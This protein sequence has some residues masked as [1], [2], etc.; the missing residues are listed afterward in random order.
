MGGL[1][2]NKSPG[3]DGLPGEFFRKFKKRLGP[4]LIRLFAD[5]QRERRVGHDFATGIVALIHKRGDKAD[6]RNYRPITLLNCDYKILMKVM[7]NR[8]KLVIEQVISGGQAYSVPGRDIAD[9]I[10]SIK[11]TLN[12]IRSR[13]GIHL[14]IDFEKAFDRV[15]H[16]FLWEVLRKFGFK[17]KFIHWIRLLY[18]N[19]DSRVKVNGLLTDR[20]PLGRSVRQGCPLSAYLYSLVAE[21]LSALLVKDEGVRGIL[22]PDGAELKIFSYADD[23][24]VFIRD[25]CSLE[26]ALACI[27]VYCG[28]SG[29][30]V[31]AL[32]S[33]ISFCGGAQPASGPLP[34]PLAADSFRV[35]GVVMGADP[36][37][38]KEEQWSGLYKSFCATL[39]LWKARKL[40][41][42]G[43]VLI[44][45]SLCVSKL[46]HVMQAYDLPR[47]WMIKF[48]E[49]ICVFLWGRVRG[50][51]A[52]ATLAGP[53]RRGGLALCHLETKVKAF[54]VEIVRK[55]LDGDCTAPWK[56]FFRASLGSW[57]R[58]SGLNL[59]L[60]DGPFVLDPFLLEIW[61]AWRSFR[62]LAIAAPQNRRTLLQMALR[63]N[64][65]LFSAP[66]GR[67][68]MLRAG[69]LEQ[70]G[71]RV[72]GDILDRGMHGDLVS[73]RSK[74]KA[75]GKVFRVGM[76]RNLVGDIEKMVKDR[77]NVA[78]RR[79]GVVGEDLDFVVFIGQHLR[80]LTGPSCR[81]IYHL[82]L[83][84][85]LKVPTSEHRWTK[86]FPAL[87]P[88]SIWAN[89]FNSH[90][91]PVVSDT[92]FKLR[93]RTILTSPQLHNFHP[94][95]FGGD[96]TMCGEPYEDIVHIF[97]WCPPVRSFWTRLLD[98][99]ARGLGFN[100]P[101]PAAPNGDDL[102]SPLLLFG[103][104]SGDASG[105]LVNLVLAFAR[106]DILRVRN[107]CLF[108]KRKLLIWPLFV[109]SINRH[110]LYLHMAAR[111]LLDAIIPPGQSLLTVTESSPPRLGP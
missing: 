70:V 109:S 93:H 8:L 34:F 15:S 64:P 13:G 72:I 12:E 1:S 61:N 39:H 87:R 66:P 100:L 108:E 101:P 29:A 18:Q 7:A 57:A 94:D 46:S 110:L 68:K 77:W 92:D 26:R 84:E 69:Y 5:I 48:K 11:Y 91:P 30:R 35:L 60:L 58:F 2:T 63:Y 6:L 19:S 107:F 90:T 40:T 103:T 95:L 106:H 99:L 81:Q 21:P 67:R 83:P 28:A 56:G 86:P 96:C 104:R 45:N 3:W 85:V 71:V 82:L 22:A 41:L 52:Y 31:N 25:S 16:E 59:C 44:V 78:S 111:D 74:F 38:C 75:A 43:K 97:A 24:N 80:P 27:G 14:N 73:L 89:I 9:S 65:D 105:R 76:I 49:A 37:R 55:F 102:E 88:A 98:L 20:I 33:S 50:P 23:T 53:G 62:R 79:V 42:K 51:V 17:N 4:I 54:R 32:K 10:L 47:S 36:S